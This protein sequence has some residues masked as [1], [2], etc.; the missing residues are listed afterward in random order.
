VGASRKRFI[1]ALTGRP[2]SERVAGSLAAAVI[3][4]ERGAS[5]LR[6]HDVAETRDALAVA[7]ATFQ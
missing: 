6:V 2:E 1:G 5:M 4:Y 3:A 7:G